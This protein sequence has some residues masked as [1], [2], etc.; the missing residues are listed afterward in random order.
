MD[1]VGREMKILRKN[2]KRNARDQ[3]HCNRRENA[4]DG[5]ISRLGVVEENNL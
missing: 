4:F 3:K 1:V 2:K 5:L